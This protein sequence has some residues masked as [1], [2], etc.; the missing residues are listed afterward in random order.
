MKMM[1]A[2]AAYA[3]EASLHRSSPP[4]TSHWFALPP[5]AHAQALRKHQNSAQHRPLTQA[6]LAEPVSDQINGLKYAQ[7]HPPVSRPCA[8]ITEGDNGWRQK[9]PDGF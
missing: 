8:G 1:T 9:F 7:F 2:A 5:A 6:S 4:V 3:P